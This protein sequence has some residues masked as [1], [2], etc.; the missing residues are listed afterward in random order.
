M[1]VR[2]DKDQQRHDT[3]LD[4]VARKI[5]IPVWELITNPAAEQNAGVPY[6][7]ESGQAV[8]YPD[9][10]AYERFTKR[11]AAVGEVETED[12]V[13]DA[14]AEEE[15]RL[16]THLAPKFFLYLPKELEQEAQRL[17]RKHRIR[18]EGLFLY[19]FTERNLFVVERSKGR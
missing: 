2:D 3:L 6:P 8:A 14:E 9:I 4:M 18:P 12:S 16:Y 10:V 5:K 15:W 19:R 11:L 1:A 13:T 7:S 17:L